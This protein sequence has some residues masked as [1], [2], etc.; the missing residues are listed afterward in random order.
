M[1]DFLI[2]FGEG[3]T[4]LPNAAEDAEQD[5]EVRGL[6]GAQAI[7]RAYQRGLGSLRGTAVLNQA[8]T[9]TEPHDLSK[10]VSSIGKVTSALNVHEQQLGELIG[11]LNVFFGAFAAQ[12]ASLRAT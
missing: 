4:R 3:L 9:G 5:P 8:I 10:L 11:N 7:N 6:N 2:G 12:S 1:Q